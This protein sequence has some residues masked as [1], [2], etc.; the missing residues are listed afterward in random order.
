MGLEP[1]VAVDPARGPGDLD[2]VGDVERAEAEVEPG[3]GG[4][5]VAAAA[6]PPGDPAPA[7]GRDRD[8]GADGVAVRGAALPGGGSASGRPSVRLW[9]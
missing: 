8:P 4:R 6:D 7:A 3:V 9:R 2:L 5:L 1:A